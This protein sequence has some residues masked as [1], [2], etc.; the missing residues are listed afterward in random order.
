[1]R[2]ILAKDRITVEDRRFIR[3]THMVNTAIRHRKKGD[4]VSDGLNL[5][6][7]PPEDKSKQESAVVNGVDTSTLTPLPDGYYYNEN[8]GDMYTP[9]FEPISTDDY[10]KMFETENEGTQ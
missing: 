10:A 2:S 4:I 7:A 3:A 8:T 5:P 6:D 9:D 1:M